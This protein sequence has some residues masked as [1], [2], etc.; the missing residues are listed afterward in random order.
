MPT[1][2]NVKNKFNNKPFDFILCIDVILLLALGVVMVL[3]ASAP[4]ALSTYRQ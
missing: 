4:S 3:S 1:K 2:K